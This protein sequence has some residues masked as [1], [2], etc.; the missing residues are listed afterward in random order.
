VPCCRALS[1]S[2]TPAC[3]CC[4]AASPNTAATATASAVGERLRRRD[5]GGTTAGVPA[6]LQVSCRF[7]QLKS[8][9]AAV[10]PAGVSSHTAAAASPQPA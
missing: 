7:K 10:M 4:P 1:P 8:P 9:S 3:T 2:H 5:T 6:L